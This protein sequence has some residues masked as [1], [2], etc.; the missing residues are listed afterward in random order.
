M[1]LLVLVGDN[2]RFP[3]ASNFALNIWHC[4]SLPASDKAT[5]TEVLL[6]YIPY[7]WHILLLCSP[8]LNTQIKINLL[9]VT[10]EPRSTSAVQVQLCGMFSSLDN[11][12]HFYVGKRSVLL[13]VKSDM[14]MVIMRRECLTQRMWGTL[15]AIATSSSKPCKWRASIDL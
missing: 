7:T 2:Q 1:R 6:F 5:A 14:M 13:I 8:P 10:A 9:A 3:S 4:H 11:E 15:A 12:T